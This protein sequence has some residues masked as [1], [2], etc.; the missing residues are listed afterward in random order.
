MS[1]TNLS[2]LLQQC[3][4]SLVHLTSHFKTHSSKMNKGCK[5]LLEKQGQIRKWN[6]SIDLYTHRRAWV[7]RLART[8]LH[9]L[10]ADTAYSFEDL[11]GAMDDRNW[12]SV[13][14]I[15]FLV[16]LYHFIQLNISKTQTFFKILMNKVNSDNLH[17]CDEWI[18]FQNST[19]KSQNENKN[20]F[21]LNFPDLYNFFFYFGCW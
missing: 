12:W 13:R 9:Q 18:I 3:L 10:C 15:T 21:P 11:L 2:L 1:L 5:T 4:A 7:S 6:S 20:N 19:N 17:S 8:Y 14:E 16:C